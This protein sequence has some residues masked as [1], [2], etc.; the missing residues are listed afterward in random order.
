MCMNIPQPNL[1]AIAKRLVVT[2]TYIHISVAT[3]HSNNVISY[4]SIYKSLQVCWLSARDCVGVAL[5]DNHTINVIGG[6]NGGV[7][8]EA[9]LASSLSR[10]EIY[11][12]N[13]TQPIITIHWIIT[14]SLQLQYSEVFSYPWLRFRT[15][16][17]VN[18]F[19]C[20]SK[21][22]LYNYV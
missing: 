13:H 7:G 3:N 4:I 18:G 1:W 10:V 19:S 11:R 9:H 2:I 22:A 14:Y 5:L 15:R 21:V 6:S 12:Y 20:L 17:A 8:V 16:F